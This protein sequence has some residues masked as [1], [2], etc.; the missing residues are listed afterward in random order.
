[1]GANAQTTVP[2]FTSGQVLTAA[3]MNQSARTGVPVFANTTDRDAG[4]GGAGEKTLAEGQ[5]C[6]VETTGFQTYNG[7]AWVTWGTS[8]AATGLVLISSTTIG[9][10]VTSVAVSNVF[11]STYTN[12][13][14]VVSGG[15]ASATSDGSFYLG[16]DNVS[17]YYNAFVYNGWPS[18]GATGAASSN[19]GNSSTTF[20]YSA[21]GYN[22]DIT[23]F[24][25]NVAA[26]TSWVYMSSTMAT[27]G[28]RWAGGGFINNATQYTG[29]TFQTQS[30]HTL[31]GGTIRV[32]GFRDS[33]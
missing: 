10:G 4:F 7:T 29:M 30:G 22:C 20:A 33:V 8:P 15:A 18:T 11:S 24:Q 14:I 3:Q 17:G 25:P 23:I 6:Y 27:T 26:R 28:N 21:N 1:M 13:K 31:T 32:Y 16:G 5:M 12:Y 19:T 2:T 9:S